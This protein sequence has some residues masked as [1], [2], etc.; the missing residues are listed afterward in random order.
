[1]EIVGE[2]IGS[3]CQ[4]SQSMVITS[5]NFT[6][7]TISLAF[8]VKHPIAFYNL[9]FMT[10]GVDFALTMQAGFRAHTFTLQEKASYFLEIGGGW[11]KGASQQARKQR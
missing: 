9:M 5:A 2:N 6:H 1:M 11:T 4:Y 8:K 7:N 3:L 10:D